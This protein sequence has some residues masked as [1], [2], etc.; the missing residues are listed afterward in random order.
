MTT[1]ENVGWVSPKGVTHRTE[2]AGLSA[3]T[4]TVRPGR[5]TRVAATTAGETTTAARFAHHDIE[6]SRERKR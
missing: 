4:R 6:N 3:P 5:Q 1:Q 2:K